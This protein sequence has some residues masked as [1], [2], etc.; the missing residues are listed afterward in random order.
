MR[1]ALLTGL[2]GRFVMPGPSGAPTRG[3]PEVL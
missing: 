3:K 2:D 1:A